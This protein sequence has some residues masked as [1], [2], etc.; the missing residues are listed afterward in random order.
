MSGKLV[1]ERAKAK[2]RELIEMGELELAKD[3][4]K[5]YKDT[6]IDDVEVYSIRAVI[7][8]MEGKME[9]AEKVLLDGYVIDNSNFDLLYNLAYLYESKEDFNKSLHYYKQARMYCKDL[10]AN[11]ELDDKINM[12]KEHLVID[13]RNNNYNKEVNKNNKIVFFVKQGMDNFLN[14]IIMNLSIDYN[15]KK[16]VISRNEDFKLID[17]WMEWA[18][19]SWFEWCDELVVYGSRISLAREKKI[20]CRIHGYEVYTN[21]IKETNW[22]N[23]DQ[24]IIVAPHI[25]RIFEE[26]TK[27]IDKGNLRID[28]I[29]CGVDTNKYQF[30]SRNKGFNLGYL[31]YINFKKNIPLTL[32]IFKKLHDIDNRY[33]LHIAGKF[34]ENRTLEYFK[35]FI[36]E[37]K[38]EDSIKF[39]GW[40]DYN[41]KVEW[42]KNIEY[43]IISSIDEGLC[44]AAAEAMCSGIKPI[45][46]NCEGI[47][48]HYDVKYIFNSIDE[49]VEMV[50][51]ENYNS[52]E[53]RKFIEDNY[54]LGKEM[55]EI[56]TLINDLSQNN[57][58]QDKTN[59]IV[60]FNYE[61]EEIKFYLPFR[62]DH[63]QKIINFTKNFYEIGMLE[64]IEMRLG[65]GKIIVDVGAN[66]GNHTIYFSK[67]CKAKKV[68]SFEPQENIFRIL[69]KNIQINGLHN[70]V[71]AYNMG[72]G[73]EHFHA[74]I[75]VIDKDNYGSSKIDTTVKGTIEINTL[76]DMLFNKV[77]RVDLIKIDVEGMEIDVLKG[78]NKIL[79]NYKPI[80][81]IEAGT[82]EEFSNVSNYLSNFN[83]KP[84]YRFNATP[85]YLFV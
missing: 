58:I 18:D 51:D 1:L 20:I 68:Y 85:T 22:L 39:Y 17:Q 73:K 38:L 62:N 69:M 28:M 5:Q 49:A 11:K 64:D 47:K 41:E 6:L 63:I 75:N 81:Y 71:V 54:S 44:F 14:D 45:L 79:G 2:T 53:Y 57:M 4:V 12:L 82:D 31:G 15:V 10:E 37:Y 84:I 55:K 67:I 52:K 33:K 40:L 77:D 61:S 36:K 13:N 70:N 59:D 76:D 34:Q 27:D 3:L 30:V 72:L 60:T 43:M 23:V 74:A 46:H 35:Y 32:D 7:A 66:I 8:M 56:K 24:L 48:D 9:E 29:F 42:F 26:R 83:Y 78:A 80:I 21:F 16:I 19:I 50:L 65:Q 25:K